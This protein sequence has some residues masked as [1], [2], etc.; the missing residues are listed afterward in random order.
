[1]HGTMTI[2]KNYKAVICCVLCVYCCSNINTAT[3]PHLKHLSCSKLTSIGSG[4]NQFPLPP[5]GICAARHL[6][7]KCR[8]R[9]GN[10]SAQLDLVFRI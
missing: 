10:A 5:D 2:K 1:M 8:L 3:S 4:Y 9:L 7:C 6:A